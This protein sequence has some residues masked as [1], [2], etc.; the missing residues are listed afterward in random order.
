MCNRKFQRNIA[1]KFKKL[2]KY[3]Y[4]LI[5]SKT[6]WKMLRKIENKNFRFIPFRSYPMCNRK[7][8]KKKSKKIQKIKNIPLWLRFKPKIGWERTRKR[9]ITIFFLFPSDRTCNRKFQKKITKFKKI[10]KYHCGFISSK[11]R[12]E[13]VEK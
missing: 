3:H 6:G 4:C 8:K 7:F 12:L 5:S 1:K 10:K 9:K 11:N 2:K 13:K